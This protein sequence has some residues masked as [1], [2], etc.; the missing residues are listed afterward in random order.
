VLHPQ[1]AGVD[2]APTE[3]NFAQALPYKL[4]K[5]VVDL[6][7]TDRLAYNNRVHQYES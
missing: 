6:N 2:F 7:R 3:V 5:I 1:A 4:L